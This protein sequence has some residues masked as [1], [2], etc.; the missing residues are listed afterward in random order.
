[1]STDERNTR[2][3]D[4]NR[5][6]RY[7]SR[8]ALSTVYLPSPVHSKYINVEVL[9][10]YLLVGGVRIED[11][12]LV[13]ERGYENL[14]TAPKG[15][16]MLHLIRAQVP[17]EPF[18]ALS[19]SS[20]AQSQDVLPRKFPNNSDGTWSHEGFNADELSAVKAELRNDS[21][22]AVSDMLDRATKLERYLRLRHQK[23]DQGSL[24]DLVDAQGPSSVNTSRPSPAVAQIIV[25]KFY[26]DMQNEFR[27]A[28]PGKWEELA[29]VES[30]GYPEIEPPLRPLGSSSP[31]QAPIIDT[32]QQL[33]MDTTNVAPQAPRVPPK[34]PQVPEKPLAYRQSMPSQKPRLDTCTASRP[35]AR[36]TFPDGSNL[37]GDWRPEYAAFDSR[38][39]TITIQKPDTYSSEKVH[40]MFDVESLR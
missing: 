28:F 10:K 4:A 2:C 16:E 29:A 14:T 17:V 8:Y 40:N 33:Q 38:F 3:L 34:T 19:Q 13:T 26:N 5:S 23:L 32:A 18:A 12:I 37:Y 11:D 15:E 1:M 35:V 31:L 24:R 7:F 20:G 25:R 6:L 30:K 39:N 27:A 21:L 36:S 22:R 9:E